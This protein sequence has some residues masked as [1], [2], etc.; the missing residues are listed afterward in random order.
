MLAKIIAWGPD[1][2]EA[3]RRLVTALENTAI[4]GFETNLTFLRLLER[5]E[6]IAGELDTGLI[7]RVFDDLAFPRP[8]APSRRRRC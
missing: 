6:V 3:R 1:R 5:P 8:R 7:A 4:F 2:E